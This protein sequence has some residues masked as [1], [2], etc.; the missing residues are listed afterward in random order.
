MTVAKLFQNG[1]SQAVRLPKDYRF[2]TKEHEVIVK[3]IGKML[4]LIP[5]SEIKNI[6]NES[7]SKFSDDLKISRSG[8]EK[9]REI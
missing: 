4:M 6:F 8:N 1:R 3:K 2:N 7:L 5:K 9:P